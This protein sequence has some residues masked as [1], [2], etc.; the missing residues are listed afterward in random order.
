MN[1]FVRW[2]CRIIPTKLDNRVLVGT[3]SLLSLF[4]RNGRI[5]AA[6][7]DKINRDKMR[8]VHNKYAKIRSFD[9][10]GIEED[11]FHELIEDQHAY[12]DMYLGMSTVAFA[13]CEVIATYNVIKTLVPDTTVTFP[14]LIGMYE[15]KGII[16]A[17]RFGV[18]PRAI[19]SL[20]KNIN[21]HEGLA[22]SKVNRTSFQLN[23][24]IPRGKKYDISSFANDRSAIIMTYYNN[25]FDLYDQIHT[26]AITKDENGYTAHNVYGNG[27]IHGPF[28]DINEL[29]RTIGSGNAGPIMLIGVNKEI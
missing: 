29:I 13:G 12:D 16:N 14:G 17:G 7:H 25:K 2:L 23:V 5:F 9:D 22:A 20:L 26:I 4:N 11:R 19:V 1:R 10:D 3:L 8:D 24:M 15:K 21:P 6:S 28:E 27:Y 18:S